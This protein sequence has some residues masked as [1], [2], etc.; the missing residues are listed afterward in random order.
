MAGSE[1]RR[2]RMAGDQTTA[3]RIPGLMIAVQLRWAWRVAR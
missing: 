1:V 2:K 3:R